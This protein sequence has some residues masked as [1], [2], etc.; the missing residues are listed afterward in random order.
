MKKAV[1]G[2]CLILFCA[3][4][5]VVAYAGSAQFT[6]QN[7]INKQLNLFV[8]DKFACGPV[9]TGGGTCTTQIT[10]DETHKFDA[11]YGMEPS[12][13]VM[14]ETGSVP[15]GGSPTMVVCYVDPQTGRC[16]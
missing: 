7:N 12:T 4:L 5:G 6:L 16:P 11:R 14:T 8:D 13:T 10:S 2:A 3:A 15:A 9:M 1:L